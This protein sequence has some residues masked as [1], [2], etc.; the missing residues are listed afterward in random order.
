MIN[1]CGLLALLPLAA[2]SRAGKALRH[3]YDD[4]FFVAENGVCHRWQVKRPLAFGFGPFC[5]HLILDGCCPFFPILLTRSHTLDTVIP[6]V[7]AGDHPVPGCSRRVHGHR[8]R[9]D[10]HEA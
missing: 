10:V 5:T 3:A 4:Q 7:P 8:G 1:K 9:K 6:I 2:A